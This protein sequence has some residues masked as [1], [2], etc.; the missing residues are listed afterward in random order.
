MRTPLTS[1]L[2]YAKLAR[3]TWERSILPALPD[4]KSAQKAVQHINDDLDV[5][6]SEGDKL[7]QLIEDVLAIADMQD[8][9]LKWL[10]QPI[11]L[12]NL[13]RQAIQDLRGQAGE[14]GLT[15]SSQIEDDLPPFVADP[16]R[17]QQLLKN[18]VSNA[19]KFT[20]QGQVTITAR[21]VQPGA[22]KDWQPPDPTHKAILVAV[23]DSGIGIAE[24]D[25]PRLFSRFQQLSTNMLTDKPAGTGLGLAICK[26]IIVH[27]GG[28]IWAE[29]VPGQGST[30]SFVLPLP[31]P[32]A[33][34]ESIA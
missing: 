12:H 28:T 14:K 33:P 5:I 13:A 26:E 16:E 25:L 9:K 1:V 32:K 18:L 4:S 2:G 29:S 7:L 24:K 11:S 6:V 31:Q 34:Q 30:F 27:Y 21:V 19:I 17:I 20:D 15:L 8:G 10:D 23:S 22:V 3:R